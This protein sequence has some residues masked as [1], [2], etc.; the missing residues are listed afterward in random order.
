VGFRGRVALDPGFWLQP[1]LG[2]S[3][4]GIRQQLVGTLL[5]VSVA[6]LLAAPAGLGLGLV[7][8][9]YAPPRVSRWVRSATL[10][11]AGVPSILLGLAGYWLFTR[12][13]GWGKSWL[14]GSILLAVIAVAPIAIAV[15]AALDG[16]PTTRRE[17][18]LA[19]GLRRDQLVRSV[20]VPHAVPGLVTG[21]LLG[22]ARAAGETAPLLL[23][24]TVFSGAPTFPD[25][26][27]D[28]PV[29]AL[30]THVFA[31][32]QDAAEPAALNAAWGAAAALLVVAGVLLITAA[33][34]R[35]R[36]ERRREL[37]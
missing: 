13:L 22:L 11:L 7:T 6:A 34:A 4:G 31:L 21:T 20:L 25:G 2:A 17:A 10:A 15:A 29:T 27:R 28:A 26:V 19:V 16:L 30:T 1:A 5:L 3:G 33:P 14:G 9:E 36:M 32:A 8:A 12:Q 18:A 24:A 23:V 37:E 35:R